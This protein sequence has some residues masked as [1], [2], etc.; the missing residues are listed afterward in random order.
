MNASLPL[1]PVVS[2]PDQAKRPSDP[3]EYFGRI[4]TLLF[5][6]TRSCN[7]TC[8]HC[9]ASASSSEHHKIMP[10]ATVVE[11]A[12]K[13]LSAGTP[14][15][16]RLVFTGGEPTLAPTAW[17]EELLDCIHGLC[18]EY[19]HTLE[20][21][22]IK[23]NLLAIDDSLLRLIRE[24]HF[25]VCLSLDGPPEINDI[26]RERTVDVVRNIDRL[27]AEGIPY[28]NIC[29][30]SAFNY[31]RLSDVIDFLV[32]L[33][34]SDSKFNPY[35]SVGRGRRSAGAIDDRQYLQGK[36]AVLND[37]LSDPRP[38]LV[39]P[40]LLNQI[41]RFLRRTPDLVPQE[42][43]VSCYTKYCAFG[44]RFSS[45]GPEGGV[46]GCKRAMSVP[47]SYQMGTVEALEEDW[48]ARIDAMQSR[49]PEWASCDACPASAVCT[50]GCP[51]FEKTDEGHGAME[52]AFTKGLYQH[53]S[54]R[55]E[56]VSDWYGE[57]MGDSSLSTRLKLSRF[58]HVMSSSLVQGASLDDDVT[59]TVNGETFIANK[60]LT[61]FRRG[62]H[63]PHS[64]L[65]P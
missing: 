47:R 25:E 9:S 27:R 6:V 65:S 46:Y 39:D 56:E 33:G 28:R 29:V 11:Y 13:V 53:L 38:R 50:Y 8:V 61:H 15:H 14:R 22:N 49:G 23:T 34:V 48:P 52:C 2:T 21:G 40:V 35:Y 4:S 26:L 12:R 62:G 18:D 5:S 41:E 64:S 42:P 20:A 30:V 7:M 16:I 57:L 1:L 51:A 60:T 3:N 63:S 54:E 58:A 24:S 43:H 36:I 55:E 32:D 31:A 10:I 59:V 37:M 45:V 44:Y 19:G 17:Y